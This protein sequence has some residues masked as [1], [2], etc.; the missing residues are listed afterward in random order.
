MTNVEGARRDVEA[1]SRD[2]RVAT[3]VGENIRNALDIID[4][5]PAVVIEGL[6]ESGKRLQL[7][8]EA[9]KHRYRLRAAII[10]YLE[11]RLHDARA[12]ER[13]LALAITGA[14][15]LPSS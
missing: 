9:P 13:E 4:E 2:A 5:Q 15:D 8:G 6:I 10:Q 1:V 14:E 7:S 3:L 12:R 11:E